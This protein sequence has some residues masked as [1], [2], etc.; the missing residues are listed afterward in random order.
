VLAALA[1][2]VAACAQLPVYNDHTK[3]FERLTAGVKTL[4]RIGTPGNV[5]AGG[6]DA[7]AIAVGYSGRTVVPFVAAARVGKG[8]A[9]AFGHGGYLTKQGFSQG[10]TLRLI[11]NSVEFNKLQQRPTRVAVYRSP[12]LAKALTA[13]G[14]QVQEFTGVDWSKELRFFDAVLSG[15]DVLGNFND[16]KAVQAYLEGGGVFVG[17]VCGWGWLQVNGPRGQLLSTNNHHNFVLLRTGL[18]YGKATISGIAPVNAAYLAPT[19]CQFA[20]GQLI[21]HRDRKTKLTPQQLEQYTGLIVDAVENLQPF[22]GIV[23]NPLDAILLQVGSSLVPTVEKPLTSDEPLL[24]LA[25]RVRHIDSSGVSESE[26]APDPASRV[27]PGRAPSNAPRE[28]RT[29]SINGDVPGWASTGLWV[30]AGDRVTVTVPDALK[31]KGLEVR[32]GMHSDK[33]WAVAQWKRHPDITRTFQIKEPVTKARNEFGGLVYIVVPNAGKLGRFQARIEGA[34]RAPRFVLGTTSDTYWTETERNLPGPWA[35]LETERIV[36]T[37][38]SEVVRTLDDPEAL[39]QQWDRVLGL[40]AELGRRPLST[41]P[42]R[43]VCDVQ[44]SVGYMHSGYPIMV[45]L[46]QPANLVSIHKQPRGKP[47]NWGFW[48]ELG[49]NHQAP[50]WTFNGTGEVTCNLFS[51]Y[52]LE[53]LYGV[54]PKDSYDFKPER[55]TKYLADGSKFTEWQAE[56]FLALTMYRQLIEGFGWEPFH[57]AFAEYAALKP[58]ERPR[59]DAQKRDQWLVRMSRATG[60]NLGPFFQRWG[61]PV[62][63]TALSQ[64]ANL[65]AWMHPDVR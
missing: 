4:P 7:F 12:E 6:P 48:H 52:V 40:Y 37:V 25:M 23:R 55:L 29:V 47:N 50:D 49:H 34:V 39:M 16:L 57:A 62:S 63:P 1:L 56:P 41:T 3:D 60:R 32:I 46:D 24:R 30:N 53:K 22:D 13:E 27:F 45:H 14:V 2:P 11:K 51:M 26:I 17:A 38:P 44:I 61:V 8:L 9:L 19:N 54:V 65:P 10:D 31:G 64:V 5:V 35:E 28:A 18:T 42:Q 36:I 58:N 33:L 59:D 43:I 21:A 15:S 20:M